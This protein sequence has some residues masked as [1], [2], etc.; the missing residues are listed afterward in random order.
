MN[1]IRNLNN[2]R[3]LQQGC[4]ATIGNFDGVHLGHQALFQQLS[5]IGKY[6]QLPTVV[7]T[8]D[9]QPQE[10][11]SEYPAARLTRLR[12][13]LFYFSS[14]AIDQVVC[15]R[16]NKALAQL[17]ASMFVQ[18]ILLK[19][20]NVKHLIVGEDFR[21]GY[22]RQGDYRFLQALSQKYGFG[23]SKAAFIHDLQGERISSTRIR[24]LLAA[25]Q[26][27]QAETLLG[28]SYRMIGRVVHG[29]QLG[30]TLGFPTAN[31]EPQRRKNPL[32]G[33]FAVKI[34][35]WKGKLISVWL[36]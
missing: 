8:F 13:K 34:M 22:Q 17:S 29:R 12:E 1:L 35:D 24:S 31:I 6:L 25:D 4:V 36:V 27:T 14:Y 19:K 2:L 18:E 16:F 30:R 3:P 11:F 33:I 10:F 26:L 28:H 7:M 15:L 32:Q 21:F 23:L 5:D 20:L 9:P